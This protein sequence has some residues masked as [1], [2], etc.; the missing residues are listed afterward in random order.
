MFFTILFIIAVGLSIGLPLWYYKDTEDAGDAWSFAGALVSVSVVVLV[1]AS[2]ILSMVSYAWSDFDL[3][4]TEEYAL[5]QNVAVE[6]NGDITVIVHEDGKLAEKTFDS[7]NVNI[8][9]SNSPSLIHVET[10]HRTADMW[11]PWGTGDE[12]FVTISSNEMVQ[13]TR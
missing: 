7:G 12:Q 11:V 6:K 10:F 8:I 9:K 5:A 3:E 2:M 13:V 4:K 1:F